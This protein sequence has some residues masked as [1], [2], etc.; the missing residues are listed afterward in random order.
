[1]DLVVREQRPNPLLKRV[2]YSFEVAHVGAAT[3]TVETVRAELAKSL[4]VP[5]DRLVIEWMRARY[6][7]PVTRGEALAYDTADALKAVTREHILI[8]NGLKEKPTEKGAEAAATE[9][10][11]AEKSAEPT[12]PA[13]AEK[14]APKAPA[15]K[16]PKAS[17]AKPKSE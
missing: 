5:K 2:E 15:E 1:M 4:K 13:P 11:P 7:T 6:G 14:P 9:A 3:P 17:E 10:P 8:R 16:S 12:P